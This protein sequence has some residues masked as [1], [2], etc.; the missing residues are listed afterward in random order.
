MTEL[1]IIPNPGKH[2]PPNEV[3][4]YGIRADNVLWLAGQ[5]SRNMDTGEAVK[6]DIELQTNKAIDN[7]EAV[8][9]TQGVGLDRVV[10]CTVFV[11]S[12]ADLE[13]MNKVYAQRFKEPRPARSAY[14]VSGMAN[15]AYRVEIDAVA[16][17]GKGPATK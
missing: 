12:S 17:H 9:K 6:G 4:S 8:L 2:N 1:K 13:G 11:T 3:L 5:T 14:I 10:R 15:P 7:I 16:I